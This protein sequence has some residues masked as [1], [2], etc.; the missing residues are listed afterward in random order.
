MQTGLKAVT[1]PDGLRLLVVDD[2][3]DALSALA[4]L[5]RPMCEVELASTKEE[6]TRALGDGSISGVITDLVLPDGNGFEIIEQARNVDP[7]LP[8]LLITGHL[9]PETAARAFAMG[10]TFLPKPV[11]PENILAFARRC[12]AHRSN[13]LSHMEALGDDWQARYHLTP[14]EREVLVAT[15]RGL[16]REDLLETR[17]IA[18]TTL[19]RH[20]TN[21]LEKTGEASLDRA[22]LRF[23][24][25]VLRDF[26]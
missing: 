22:A 6:A 9:D 14:T 17:G 23:L 26:E 5:L 16:S 4:R 11:T 24:R 15:A 20:V 10:V 8:A 19:K 3:P 2:D 21:L 25:E 13:A 18:E 1:S 7:A 12:V